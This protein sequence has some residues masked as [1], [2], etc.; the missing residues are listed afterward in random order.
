MENLE[1]NE[2]DTMQENVSA[3]MDNTSAQL[4]FDL[5]QIVENVAKREEQKK[6]LP[7]DTVWDE[8][9]F[10]S[11]GI[12]LTEPEEPEEEPEEEAQEPEPVEEEA[13]EAESIEAAGEETGEPEETEKKKDP[14]QKSVLLYIHDLAYLLA[15]IIVVF[16]LL[17]RV[18]V[19]SGSSMKNTLFNGDYLLLINNVFYG[20]PKQGDVIVASKDSFK[21]GAP[22][23]KRVIAT[24]GQTVHID[25]ENGIVYVDGKEIHEPY[26]LGSTTMEEGV[27]FPLTVDEGCV[28][29]L[30][31]NRGD[32]KDSRDPEIGLIDKREIMGKVVFLFFPGH[33][34]FQQRDFGRIGV[35]S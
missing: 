14:W 4:Q 8:D 5:A 32:S 27:S 7:I 16:L 18:V 3:E 19:V 34:R 23:V 10:N 28:F 22:I 6:L 24:E 13:E 11:L 12:D 25:F 35:V 31:D 26:I 20:N 15:I 33:D 2:L 17:F 1:H 29:V 9:F 30:G 21:D